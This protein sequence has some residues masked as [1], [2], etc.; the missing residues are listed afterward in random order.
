MKMAER[1]RQL[2]ERLGELERHPALSVAPITKSRS[3]AARVAGKRSAE[4]RR[5]RNGSAQPKSNPNPE[6][7]VATKARTSAPTSAP[8]DDPGELPR[9]CRTLLDNP[10]EVYRLNPAVL[11]AV[12]RITVA[13]LAPFGVAFTRLGDSPAKDADLRAI[14]EALAAGYTVKELERAG[15]LAMRDAAILAED[16]PGP[17]SFT[18]EVL[19]RLIGAPGSA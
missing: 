14:L 5:A 6:R 9:T 16:S 4:V 2:E 18:A 12:Q 11:A 17:S 7:T 1:V 10:D 19:Q 15:D 13:W 3:E 8:N